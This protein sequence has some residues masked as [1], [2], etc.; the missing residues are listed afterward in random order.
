MGAHLFTEYGKETKKAMTKYKKVFHTDFPSYH[1][2]YRLGGND[3]ENKI[4]EVIDECLS[5]G[6]DVYALGYL[7]QEDD[8]IQY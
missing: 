8:L 3:F 7:T 2:E 1:Y 4:I 6:K 5:K